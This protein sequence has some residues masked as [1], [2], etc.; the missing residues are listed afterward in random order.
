MNQ[1]LTPSNITFGIG[2]IGVI[3]TIVNYFR[4]PQID[5]DKKTIQ[6]QDDLKALQKE[7]SEIKEKHLNTIE[8]DLK[9]LTKTIFALSNNVT[10]LSTIIDE[11]VPKAQ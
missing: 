1:L 3:F 8:A 9:E 10:R 11:R 7:V 6:L 5:G 4:N 2:I